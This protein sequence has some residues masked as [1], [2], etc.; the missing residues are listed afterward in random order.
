MGFFLFRKAWW[1][2][3]AFA[4]RGF[5]GK[6]KGSGG[7]GYEKRG[8]SRREKRAANKVVARDV[9]VDRILAKVGTQG[10][11]SLTEKEKKALADATKSEQK[12][13]RAG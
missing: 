6:G 7:S 10:M 9:E 5:G 13:R 8:P 4:W 2:I 3:G 1:L 11:H 12:K